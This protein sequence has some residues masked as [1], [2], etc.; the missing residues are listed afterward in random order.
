MDLDRGLPLSTPAS[1]FV[2][3]PLMIRVPTWNSSHPLGHDHIVLCFEYRPILSGVYSPLHPSSE[4]CQNVLSSF[5]WSF[6]LFFSPGGNRARR[7]SGHNSV[8]VTPELF[9][10]V[11][12]FTL[13]A[14]GRS[15]DGSNA[16][17]VLILPVSSEIT[18]AVGIAY[19]DI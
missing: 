12:R 19:R 4:R 11:L 14:N 2:Y 7:I 13:Y 9:V 18:T 1:M 10:Q 8:V 17:L 15:Y 16:L 3:V 6:L 5:F